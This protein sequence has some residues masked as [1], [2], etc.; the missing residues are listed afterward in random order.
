ME[1]RARGDF[2][3]WKEKE[4]EEFWGQ[5]Q[6]VAHTARA[7]VATNIKLEKLISQGLFRIGD[8]WSY[9][10]C[11]G[12]GE[13][14]VVVE[15]DCELVGIKAANVTFEMPRGTKKY[16]SRAAAVTGQVD[17]IPGN[18]LTIR[19]PKVVATAVRIGQ[20]NESITQEKSTLASAG[21]RLDGGGN[22][23]HM[24]VALQSPKGPS[25]LG[26][27][28]ENEPSIPSSPLSSARSDV[29]NPTDWARDK[30]E[31][32]V[33]AMHHGPNEYKIA[34]PDSDTITYSIRNL[35][36]LETKILNVDGR[37]KDVPNGNAWKTFRLIRHNQDLG[38]LFDVRD[39]Y[40][41]DFGV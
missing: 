26:L 23:E 1:E 31:I 24:T 18:E 33:T 8:I 6:K 9:A 38:S 14:A 27:V 29:A 3:A 36:A 41:V 22:S 39:K 32:P 35:G 34:I 28:D 11:F 2:D 12:R 17:G 20:A 15:K 13:Q 4:F 16:R 7:G 19:S 37:V 30:V 40:C 5:K 10:R 25:L 21:Q